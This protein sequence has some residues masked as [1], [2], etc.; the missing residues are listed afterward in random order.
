MAEIIDVRVAQER[1]IIC[2]EKD[3]FVLEFDVQNPDETPFSFVGFTGKLQVRSRRVE[4]DPLVL[5]IPATLTSGHVYLTKTATQMAGISGEYVYDFKITTNAGI[6]E[7]WL[8]GK[9]KIFPTT[10]V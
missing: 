1:D 6:V 2:H 7:T 10:T 5:E 8:F 4:S 3:D 9:F